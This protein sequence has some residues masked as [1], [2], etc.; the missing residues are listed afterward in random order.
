MATQCQIYWD[1]DVQ[2]YRMKMK[3][4]PQRGPQIVDFLKK[5]IPSSERMWDE[6]SKIWTFTEK[7]FDGVQKFAKL[8]FGTTEVVV[9]TR[10]QVEAASQSYSAPTARTATPLELE[11]AEFMR[12]LPFEAAQSAY[13]RAAAM[14]HPDKG[15]SMDK[16]SRLNVLWNRLEKEVYNQ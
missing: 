9:L 11:L 1:K 10:T 3:W 6:Q 7:Y 4:S 5:Q 8:L 14:L 15:G 2:A 16:M 12:L 13:R